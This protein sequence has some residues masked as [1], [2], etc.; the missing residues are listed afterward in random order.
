MLPNKLRFFRF[1][2]L[3]CFWI[4][5]KL[6]FSSLDNTAMDEVQHEEEYAQEKR[7]SLVV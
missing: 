7:F 5:T 6:G 4:I 2:F 1:L 3:I